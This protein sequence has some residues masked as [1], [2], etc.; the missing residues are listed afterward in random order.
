MMSEFTIV[1]ADDD[2]P[3]RDM[4]AGSLEMFGYNILQAAN[5]HEA[6]KLIQDESVDL[7]LSDLRMPE[8][9]GL[10]LLKEVQA[11]NPL[12][13]VIMM[14]AFGTVETAVEAMQVGA[15]N[16][17]TKPIDLSS[18]KVLVERALEYKLLREEVQDLRLRTGEAGFG[19]IIAKSEK[20]REVLSLVSRV[21]SSRASV[22]IL[23]ESGTGKEVIARALHSASN[24]QDK[25][26][27]AVNIAA[28]PETLIES[29]LFGHEKGA[30]T[31]AA[32]TH[33]GR[34]EKADKGTLFIDEIGDMPLHSQVKLLR[35]LQE[36]TFER[37][38]GESPLNTDV[39]VVAATHR[40]LDA[41]IRTGGFRE[42]LFYRLNV[43]RI[44][45]PPL[46]ER[47][48]DIPALV[49]H[50][51]ERYSN[52]N[53]KQVKDIDTDA[54][55]LLMKYSW[56]GNVRELE[57]A[58][59]SAVVL[60]RSSRIGT[61]DLPARLLGI[62]RIEK[63]ECF[64]GDDHA[65]PLPERVEMFEKHFVL[66]ALEESGGNKAEAAR[67]LKMSDKNIRDRLKRWG[68]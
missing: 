34:F 23:G 11:L 31:G 58:I 6:L 41:E 20:M 21:A 57:N 49:E 66:K 8:M 63:G 17:I 32:G 40:D 22:L 61:R 24:R 25:P 14:T 44:S 56:P 19:Q 37:V 5:G 9:D 59:E 16:F 54:T 62:T 30:F 3:Q 12:V 65:M 50:F 28:I 51:I 47:K 13:T 29:E 10:E 15:F 38:G 1:L 4:L 35:V 48:S 36:G 45:I 39:R 42:D 7:L 60:A 27:V 53:D 46:R 64:P 18:L 43:V 33:A 55:D 67:R 68:G 26:F 52:L 2:Q